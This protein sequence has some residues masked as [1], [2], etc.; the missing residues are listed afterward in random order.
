MQHQYQQ[1]EEEKPV[2]RKVYT[3]RDLLDFQPPNMYSSIGKMNLSQKPSAPIYGFGTSDRKQQAKVFH[4]KELS[5]TQF[6]G[7]Y[8]INNSIVK[9]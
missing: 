9:V 5:T 3:Q 2:V 4:S 6:V 8:W 7:N 1:E